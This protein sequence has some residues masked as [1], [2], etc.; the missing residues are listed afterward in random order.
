MIEAL[1]QKVVIVTS[2]GA[3]VDNASPTTN[4]IDTLGYDHL[5]ILTILGATDIAMAAL[6]LTES[7]VSGSDH[8][9]ISGANFATASNSQGVVLPSANADD[10]VQAFNVNLLG[11]KR[12]IDVVATGGDGTTGAYI[13][14]I[15]LL[16]RAD[17]A[18][19]NATE[20]GV[21]Q[22]LFV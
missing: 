16:S 1:N 8:A 20:R 10:T 11:R 22:E 14:I 4:E 18:P 5:R 7:D 3:I 17:E 15:A 13:T 6:K 2:P 21:A 9:D 19:N 12:Y